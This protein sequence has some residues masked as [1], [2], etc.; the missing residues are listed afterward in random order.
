[1]EFYISN[2]QLRATLSCKN[3]NYFTHIFGA[4]CKAITAITGNVNTNADGK[5]YFKGGRV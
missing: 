3:I 2:T 5:I 1:L 4:G